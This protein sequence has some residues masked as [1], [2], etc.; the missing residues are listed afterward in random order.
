MSSLP[1][2]PT[3][4]YRTTWGI[5]RNPREVLTQWAQTF[6]DPFLITAM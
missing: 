6:G 3:G 1:P 2:G 5:L 4:R